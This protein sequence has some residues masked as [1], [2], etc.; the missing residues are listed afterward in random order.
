M[1]PI[2]SN[3]TS[4]FIQHAI[5]SLHTTYTHIEHLQPIAKVKVGV[6]RPVQQPGS[7]WDRSS[8]LPLVGLEP[9]EVTAYD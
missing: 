3:H 8:E 4:T 7:Y 9:T 6:L 2:T 1:N 5:L